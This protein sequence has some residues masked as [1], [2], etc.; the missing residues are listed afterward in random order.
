MLWCSNAP[1]ASARQKH[2]GIFCFPNV[3]YLALGLFGKVND[4]RG[5]KQDG[6]HHTERLAKALMLLGLI[7]S[8]MNPVVRIWGTISNYW[9]SP[10]V[11][12]P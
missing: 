7:V 4:A 9:I 1:S 5:Q 6:T 12:R 3:I 10:N 2:H 8:A 11:S